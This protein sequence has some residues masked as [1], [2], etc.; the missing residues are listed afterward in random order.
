VVVVTTARLR[1]SQAPFGPLPENAW[2]RT[3][4]RTI[5][6]NPRI[7]GL[8]AY[9]EEIV[10]TGNWEPLVGEETWRAVHALLEDPG[11]KPPRGVRTLLSGLPDSIAYTRWTVEM[12]TFDEA[13]ISAPVS[14]STPYSSA[15]LR[16]SSGVT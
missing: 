6:L 4:I 1:P 14:R 5:L 7:A 3:S 12:T 13:S 16:P 9:H 15:S 2:S 8:S 11:R 10:G